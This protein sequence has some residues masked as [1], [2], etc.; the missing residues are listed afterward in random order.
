[1]ATT[2]MD[3]STYLQ[4]R[5]GRYLAQIMESFEKQIEPLLPAS[6]AGEVQDF[7]GLLRARLN[8]LAVDA[9]D[10]MELEARAMAQNGAAQHMRD[11]IS[12]T[13]RP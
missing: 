1:M 11:Q 5:R 3:R 12:P 7:K 8:A 4:K 10:L 13:G 2:G 9:I 6:A